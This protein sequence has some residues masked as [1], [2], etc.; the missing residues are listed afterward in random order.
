M[1]NEQAVIASILIDESA[2]NRI[3]DLLTGEDFEDERCGKIYHTAR[4]LHE[5]G[6]TVDFITISA[7]VCPSIISSYDLTGFCKIIP[8]AANVR[9][10]A[11]AV[12]ESSAKRKIALLAERMIHESSN[13]RTASEILS[14]SESE[15]IEIG[16]RKTSETIGEQIH[17]AMEALEKGFSGTRTGYQDLDSLIGGYFP[18]ELVVIAARPGVGK[19]ALAL[20][21]FSRLIR[22]GI[23]TAFLSIEMSFRELFYRYASMETSVPHY[24]MRHNKLDAE[25]WIQI[26]SVAAKLSSAKCAIIDMPGIGIADVQAA[27]IRAKE[28]GG[29]VIFIDYLGL[30][31]MPRHERNKTDQIGAVT[32]ALKGLAKRYEQTVVLLCQLNRAATMRP[33]QEPELEDLRGSGE[34]EQDADIVIFPHH[35]KKDSDEYKLL[36]KKNRHGPLGYI[37]LRHEKDHFRFDAIEIRQTTPPSGSWYENE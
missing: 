5:E 12:I 23:G 34:I 20:N 35:A 31:E 8:S 11:E 30:M 2:I 4:M 21:L 33:D 28:Y 17:R 24:R 27:M 26:T 13:G 7:I 10:Y 25:D 32:R 15:L 16:K 37:T 19:T 18:Q 36:I 3:A 9:S 6:K 29:K 1:T 22:G 14:E